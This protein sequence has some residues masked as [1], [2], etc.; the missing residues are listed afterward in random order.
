MPVIDLDND[1]FSTIPIFRGYD[2]RGKDCNDFLPNVHPGVKHF[3]GHDQTIDYNC[4]GISG[5]DTVTGKSYKDLLCS[6]S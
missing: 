5:T 1:G 2:F 6:G 3:T 4:N